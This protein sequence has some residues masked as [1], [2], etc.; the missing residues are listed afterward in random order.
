MDKNKALG[1]LM[2]ILCFVCIWFAISLAIQNLLPLSS[3]DR[4]TGTIASAEEVSA[5]KKTGRRSAH[6]ISELRIQLEGQSNYYRFQEAASYDRFQDRILKGHK[7]DIYTLPTLLALI[8]TNSSKDIFHLTVDNQV[9]YSVEESRKNTKGIMLFC[10]IAAPV[11]YF[12][13]RWLR[14]ISL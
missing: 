1:F 6:E 10:L 9:L 4:A 7:A 3:Y 12:V 11:F 5:M 14:N 13:G 2:F 8:T